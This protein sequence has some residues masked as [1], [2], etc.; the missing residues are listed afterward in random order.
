[1]D[2]KRDTVQPHLLCLFEGFNQNST[3]PL[4]PK[5]RPRQP[6]RA[7]GP[8][9]PPHSLVSPPSS[10]ARTPAPPLPPPTPLSPIIK[11]KIHVLSFNQQAHPPRTGRRLS[12]QPPAP[13]TGPDYNSSPRLF[14]SKLKNSGLPV[15][16]A[17]RISKSPNSVLKNPTPLP[18][19]E[20]R[21]AEVSLDPNPGPGLLDGLLGDVP[22]PFS[23]TLSTLHK[24]Q[25]LKLGPAQLPA[26]QRGPAS[27]SSPRPL[28]G[29]PKQAILSG[30]ASVS[31]K[32]QKET[33]SPTVRDCPSGTEQR[34]DVQ[35]M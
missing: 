2:L 3:G 13:K 9:S 8:L 28:R 24:S 17:S 6:P 23:G 34:E 22:G 10:F 15:K 31:P 35:R 1:M 20:R 21:P 16:T 33:I 32:S 30:P 11:T 25:G 4:D 7:T 26:S 18:S 14:G 5:P 12:P 27:D 19:H 29:R